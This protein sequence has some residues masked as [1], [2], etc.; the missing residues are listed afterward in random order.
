M[1]TIINE[2]TLVPVSLLAALAGGIFWLSSMYA[3]TQANAQA[4]VEIK[5]TQKDDRRE[6][7]ER[8]NMIDNKIDRLLRHR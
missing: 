4:V 2:K 7:I 5:E 3:Q 6:I 8:L 1:N